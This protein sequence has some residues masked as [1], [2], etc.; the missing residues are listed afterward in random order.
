MMLIPQAMAYATLAGLR[1][2]VGLYAAVLPAMIYA[3]A[4]SSR[5]LAIGPVAI[6]ALLISSGLSEL[7]A[8][9]TETY[10]QHA[11]VLAL[12]V[13][14]MFFGLA[15]VRAG[16]LV[17]FLSHPTIVGFNAGAAIL[18]AMSQ[19]SPLFGV[20]KIDVSGLTPTWP[21]PI[22]GEI[23]RADPMTLLIGVLALVALVSLPR[24]SSKLPS[25]LVVCV[26][27]VAAVWWW[28]LDRSGVAV[29]G[30]IPLQL[31]SLRPPDIELGQLSQ[32]FPTAASI[33]V[34]GFVSSMTVGTVLATKARER[35]NPNRELWAFGFANLGAGLCGAFPVSAGLAR[36]SIMFDAGARTRLA[37]FFSSWIVIG[38]LVVFSSGFR[39]LPVS[40][41]A[42][43][44]ISAAAKLIDLRQ[45][46]ALFRGR[47][48][49]W[50]TMLLTCVATLAIGLE[51]GL[52]SGIL[53]GF[54]LFIRRTAVPHSAE[55]GRLPG[56]TIYRNIGRF[57]TQSCPQAAIL[58]IDAP[59]Y[60]GNA[61][62]LERRVQKLFVDHLDAHLAILDFSSV[63]DID[64]TALQ[65]LGRIVRSTREAGSDIHIVSAIGPVRDILQH[66]GVGRT[67]GANN[68]HRTLLEAVPQIMA[69][70][71]AGYCG[72]K[73]KHSAFVDCDRIHRG[74][75]TRV[76][77]LEHNQV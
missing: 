27:A 37:G 66:S 31:P 14:A 32:L 36:S 23:G 47:L 1:P 21:W 19:V 18:T 3:L 53:V 63:S 62:F 22:L 17:N 38:A 56:T 61:Q 26:A 54:A 28:D 70:V 44:V 60:F 67:I 59:L 7:A 8:P 34:I 39:L 35:M 30:G 69:K 65:S 9:G 29:V 12:M 42:A 2:E 46:V 57:E 41:L 55:L 20:N 11:V 16:F 40:V 10:A 77:K 68:M 25:A 74:P 4:G 43:L 52:A 51:Q 15:A 6:V 50:L 76:P 24:L 45:I 33:V 73:C 75:P 13:A 58:R 64:A 72:M 48:D 71:D 5:F 49:G